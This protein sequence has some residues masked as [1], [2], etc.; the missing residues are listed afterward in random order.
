M[1]FDQYFDTGVRRLDEHE[2][3]NDWFEIVEEALREADLASQQHRKRL[4][5]NLMKAL[6]A[7]PEDVVDEP[8]VVIAD[9]DP[10]RRPSSVYSVD[11]D[12]FAP[13]QEKP[14]LSLDCTGLKHPGGLTI[15]RWPSCIQTADL[16]SP[17]SP[18]SSALDCW[19]NSVYTPNESAM[20]SLRIKPCK[21]ASTKTPSPASGWSSSTG[22][23]LPARGSRASSIYSTD[24]SAD[25]YSSY[26]RSCSLHSRDA[27]VS[28]MASCQNDNMEVATHMSFFDF[29]DE[30]ENDKNKPGLARS[31]SSGSKYVEH[32][33]KKAK[34]IRIV[35]SKITHP[36]TRAPSVSSVAGDSP[37]FSAWLHRASQH[38][39]A[40]S[41]SS[42]SPSLDGMDNQLMAGAAQSAKA[43]RVLGLK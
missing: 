38:D 24:D 34:S 37:A 30:D 40:S 42:M 9:Y 43:K 31:G 33:R 35:T 19:A 14:S 22:S 21:S 5:I 18:E 2:D 26:A 8:V 6:P 20:C 39:R 12:H 4:E 28:T 16:D 13:R 1:S 25:S 3:E 32:L 29:S 7:I 27:S 17:Q 23:S 41:I 15:T 36:Q 10:S 11:I